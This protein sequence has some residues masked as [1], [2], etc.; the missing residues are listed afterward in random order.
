[1]IRF[2]YMMA[3]DLRRN[4]CLIVVMQG[5]YEEGEEKR[6]PV[7][8]TTMLS[9]GELATEL[10]RRE[11]AGH[12]LR[13]AI[14]LHLNDSSINEALLYVSYLLPHHLTISFSS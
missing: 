7:V 2:N 12:E 3:T 14:P 10:Q 1:M 9:I 11:E 6:L 13:K 4:G 8:G 5:T